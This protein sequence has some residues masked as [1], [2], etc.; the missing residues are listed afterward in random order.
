MLTVQ[1]YPL[2]NLQNNN[3][4]LPHALGKQHELEPTGDK[5]LLKNI[6]E[7][8]SINTIIEKSNLKDEK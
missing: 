4:Y 6:K 1:H 8:H 2:T 5:S 7:G 3:Y